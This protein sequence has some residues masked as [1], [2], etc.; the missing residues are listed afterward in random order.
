MKKPLQ[1]HFRFLRFLAK[2]L[3]SIVLFFILSGSSFAQTGGI[4]QDCFCLSNQTVPGNGQFAANLVVTGAAAGETW[5]IQSVTGLYS[6]TS[7]VPP[8]N[9]IPFTTGPGGATMTEDIADGNYYFSGIHVDGQGFSIT[10]TNGVVV[11]PPLT[12]AAGSCTYPNAPFAGD[13]SVCEQQLQSYSV[14]LAVGNTYAWTLAT[15]G[16]FTTPANSN[17]VTVQWSSNNPGPHALG[18]TQTNNLGCTVSRSRWITIEDTL[19]M[20]CND[21]VQISLSPACNDEL[22]ADMFLEGYQY[23]NSAYTIFFETTDGVPVAGNTINAS[24]LWQTFVVT[25]LHNCS[26]NMCWSYMTVIEKREPG[27]VGSVDTLSCF[28][29]VEP[30]FTGF[31]VDTISTLKIGEKTYLVEAV[32]YCAPI[33][34]KYEDTIVEQP[35]SSEFAT[36]ITRKWWLNDVACGTTECTDILKL[37][38]TGISLLQF[39]KSWDG[40]AGNNSILEACGPWDKLPN[41]HPSPVY[42][43]S[44]FGPNCG[45]IEI[46]FTDVKLPVCG[47][48]SFKILRKWLVTDWCTSEIF[49]TNQVIVVMDTTDPAVA[50]IPDQVYSAGLNE[51]GGNIIL[52]IPAVTDCSTWTYA[53]AYQLADKNGNQPPAPE[54][55]ITDARVKKNADGSYSLLDLP[56]GPTWV[57]YTIIDACDNRTE[58]FFKITIVDQQK[59]NA[60]CDREVVVALDEYGKGYAL[61]E[62]FDDGSWD[63]CGPVT[64]KARRGANSC[65]F[66]A[67][68]WRDGVEFCCADVG[69]QTMVELEVK[70]AKGFTNTCMSVVEVQDHRVPTMTC[71]PDITV[72]CKFDLSNLNV[73]GTVVNNP[74]AA[75]QIKLNDPGNPTVGPNYIWGYDG[76]ATDNCATEISIISTAYNL[77]DC[78]LGTIVRTF[79]ATDPQGNFTTCQQTITVKNFTP[80][81][82]NSTAYVRW[83]ADHTVIGCIGEDVLPESLPA[84]KQEPVIINDECALVEFTYSDLVFQYVDNYCYKIIRTWKMIDWCQ[85]DPQDPFKKGYWEHHQLIMVNDLTPPKFISGCNHVTTGQVNDIDCS[86]TLSLSAS[87]SDNCTPPERLKWRYEIDLNNDNS[88]NRT[89]TSNSVTSNFPYGTHKIT[90]FVTDECGNETSCSSNFTLYDRKAPTPICYDGLVTVPMQSTGT[91]EIYAKSFNI[92]SGCDDGSFDNCTPGDKLRFSFSSNVNNISRVFSCDDIVNGVLDTIELEMWVTDLAGNQDFCTAHLILQDNQNACPDVLPEQ[93]DI[94][95]KITDQK[96]QKLPSVE[97]KLD[98]DHSA[99]GRFASTDEYGVYFFAKMNEG[100]TYSITPQSNADPKAGISTLDLVLIQQ[101]LLGVKLLDSPEKVI[102]ADANN[103]GSISAADIYDLRRLIL[104]AIEQLPKNRSWRFIPANTEF[105]NSGNPFPFEEQILL[106][107]F[108]SHSVQNNFEGIKI[109]DINQSYAPSLQGNDVSGRNLGRINMLT[110]NGLF[111]AKQVQYVTFEIDRDLNAAGLQFTLNYDPSALSFDRVIS[112]LIDLNEQNYHISQES[113]GVI[114]ISWN[115]A[116]GIEFNQGG[117]MFTIAFNTLKSGVLSESLRLGSEITVAEIYPVEDQEI[118]EKTLGLEFRNN[119]LNEQEF[120]LYQNTP[121][122]FTHE[123]TIRYFLPEQA[124]AKLS[125]Y[126]MNGKLVLSKSQES[127]GYG[128]FYLNMESDRLNPGIYMYTLETGTNKSSKRMIM[129]K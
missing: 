21:T 23:E 117:V 68:T 94:V 56:G 128:E 85:F 25:V 113:E 95:G 120:Q 125:I 83:P 92:C 41:G 93:Y 67:N 70:D 10:F 108:Y 124:Q 29:R 112:G 115:N 48:K 119:N 60:I 18:L 80:F 121:N 102:A 31:P 11:L 5:Y 69:K 27:L 75:K 38:R 22:V 84:G 51:C 63:N 91:V 127:K 57:K 114:T 123:T 64:F 100:R 9:P 16:T 109:G 62:T 129:I 78:G 6:P 17:S 61:A 4:L 106:T 20:A 33:T 55:Y 52:P 47:T 58:I 65:G 73:F 34:L 2:P 81:N 116:Q 19:A 111:T 12:V 32:G 103:S 118:S 24:H 7:P 71:P 50:A 54:P 74:S 105:A 86:A 14:P 59:P 88:V 36:I 72:S 98:M 3:L 42:T 35:C 89:G 82:A 101:H 76:V 66:P 1:I 53:V 39:P 13:F 99:E 30:E 46:D 77:N 110:D 87:A 40:V 122:P 8:A 104:G 79:K 15:G 90:W 126:D 97:V 96:G 28:E 107:D 37:T 26:S 45:N 49:D 43:G 44:P